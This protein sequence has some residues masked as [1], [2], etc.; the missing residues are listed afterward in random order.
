MHLSMNAHFGIRRV[1]LALGFAVLIAANGWPSRAVAVG[2]A[3]G[4]DVS[5]PQCG[6]ALP[7]P[8]AFAV[9]GVNRGSPGTL[10]P[11]F[12][13]EFRWG[14]KSRHVGTAVS[15]YINSAN[16]GSLHRRGWP[17]SD[18]DRVL[19]T[20]A[21]NPFGRCLGENSRACGWQF[22][23]NM[24]ERDTHGQ[25]VGKINGYTWWLDVE[26]MNNWERD[27]Q[28]NRAVLAGMTS[29]LRKRGIVVGIYCTR[30]QWSVIAGQVSPASILYQLPEWLTG[31]STSTGARSLCWSQPLTGGGS[32][33][34][35]QW[36][37]ARSKVDGD[38]MC[39]HFP[40][41]PVPPSG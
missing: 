4:V 14:M 6:L 15:L 41:H 20:P 24:A 36:F 37:T 21:P 35:A 25:H 12:K 27:R 19:G 1:I 8:P 32:V 40:F 26:T 16:P 11:C 13:S 39:P 18:V 34:M 10:N 7:H 30:Y 38:V 17:S 28:N 23:W 9:V 2:Y 5:W 22:G 3:V 29:Y 31:A 33:V